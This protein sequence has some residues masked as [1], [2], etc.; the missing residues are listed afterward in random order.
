M[1]DPIIELLKSSRI[2]GRETFHDLDPMAKETIRLGGL[3]HDITEKFY[4]NV[5]PWM[6]ELNIKASRVV[7]LERQFIMGLMESAEQERQRA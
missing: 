4:K 1:K 7:E 3:D 6:Q 5:I 2:A